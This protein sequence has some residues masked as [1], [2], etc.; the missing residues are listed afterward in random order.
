MRLKPRYHISGIEGIYYERSPFR[1]PLLGEHDTTLQTVTRF[2]G[3]ARVG[4]PSKQKWIYAL[5]LTP[6]DKMKFSEL[7]QK[8]TDETDCPYNFEDLDHESMWTFL[9]KSFLTFSVW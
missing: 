9:L 7:V 2:I 4:N 8:T 6:L 3:L 5:N 1:C